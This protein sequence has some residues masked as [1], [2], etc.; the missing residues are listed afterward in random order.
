GN[1]I[2]AAHCDDRVRNIGSSDH[3]GG[4]LVVDIARSAE[5]QSEGCASSVAYQVEAEFAVAAFHAVVYFTVRN[6]RFT[7]HN[8]EVIDEGFH[9]VINIFFGWQIEV[10]HVW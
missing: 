7:H 10:W 3:F 5:M 6:I 9:I 4:G 8:F 1:H 2:H